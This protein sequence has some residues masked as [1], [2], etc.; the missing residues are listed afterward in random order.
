MYL[1]YLE[2]TSLS[3]LQRD[4][5]GDDD[6]SVDKETPQQVSLQRLYTTF[7]TR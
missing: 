5:G 1:K 6:H 7:S 4:H 2:I 3:I